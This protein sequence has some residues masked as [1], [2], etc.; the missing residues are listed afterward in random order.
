MEVLH[1]A[2]RI[3]KIKTS[4]R[5]G[6]WNSEYNSTYPTD[7][8]PAGPNS[9]L[10]SPNPGSELI[11]WKNIYGQVIWGTFPM[12]HNIVTE[13]WAPVAIIGKRT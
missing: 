11:T 13:D 6:D 1:Q 9:V 4:N 8:S 3:A 5:R 12:E 7:G 10:N 2:S